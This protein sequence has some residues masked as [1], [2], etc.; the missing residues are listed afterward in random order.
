GAPA[1]ASCSSPSV[2]ISATSM[3]PT[4]V[5]LMRPMAPI[6]LPIRGF[7]CFLDALAVCSQVRVR[8][9]S[10]P[11]GGGKRKGGGGKRKGG[12]GKHKGGGGEHKGGGSAPGRAE[13]RPGPR[14]RARTRR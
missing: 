10:Q 2:A 12:G 6:V 13:G 7:L 4:E 5:P 14:Q 11:A 9:L 8:S 1:R 3:P